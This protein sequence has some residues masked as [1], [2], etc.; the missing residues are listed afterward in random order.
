MNGLV[1][2][3]I[4]GMIYLSGIDLALILTGFTKN[5]LH[6]AAILHDL[7]LM[8]GKGSTRYQALMRFSLIRS[9]WERG[10]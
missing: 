7:R 10:D 4:G 3:S 9:F 2:L 8:K 5:D 1:Y 6:R